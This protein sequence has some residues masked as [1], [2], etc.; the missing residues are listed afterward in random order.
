MKR[1]VLFLLLQTVIGGVQAQNFKFGKVSKEEVLEQVH[2]LDKE[3]NAA[4][5]FREYKVSYEYNSFSGFTL[6]TRVHERIKIYNKDGFDWANKVISVYKNNSKREEVTSIKG[7]TYNINDGKVE[8]EKLRNNG[9]LEEE[10][11]KY[12]NK[13]TLTMPAVKEG[14]VVEYE[15]SIRSPFLTSIDEI[16]LQY[17]IPTNRLEV[18]VSV[19]EFLGF[20]KHF[21]LKS[22]LDFPLTE[23]RKPVTHKINNVVNSR[24]N[25]VQLQ[26]VSDELSYILNIY[27]WTKNNIPALEEENHIDYLQNYAASL[28]WELQYTKFPNQVIENYAETW[29][30]VTS[31]IYWDEGYE[32]ELNRTGFFEEDLALVLK[33]LNSAEEK[34][35]AI[36]SFLKEKVKWNGYFGYLPEKG[37]RSAYKDGEG[38]VGDLNTL[39]TSML[40][41]AGLKAY[42]VLVSSKSNGIPVF[43]TRQGFN[44]V[45]SAVEIPGRFIFLDATDPNSAVNELPHRARNWQGRLIMDKENSTWVDIM[46]KEKSEHITTLNMKFGE[47]LNLE[48]KQRS[49]YSGLFAKRYRDT[50]MG[51]S[52]E[53]RLQ[54]LEKGKGNID[55]LNLKIEN[56]S[57][58]GS[59]VEQVFDFQL[60]SAVESIG[61]RIYLK[62][63]VYEA[64]D[65]SPFKADTRKYPIFFDFPSV[66]Q[67][68]VNLMV[69]TGYVV[70][71]LP[72]S[73]VLELN[74]GAGTFTFQVIQNKNFLRIHSVLEIN[75]IAFTPADYGALQDF[76]NKLV[77]KHTEAIV[78]K[79]S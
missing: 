27:E 66:H 71:T 37:T 30:G 33:D 47:D 77:D 72:E 25:S 74:S 5:L 2:P 73:V 48:G 75:N 15:Y 60:K 14:S 52:E 46:P 53:N 34:I 21:N 56:E 18:T 12:W 17:T 50:Y 78:F 32:T 70:E 43:P 29:E 57:L 11:N 22:G 58:I 51:T 68:T 40:K 9:I 38:N 69:P 54:S 1:I 23:S 45:I 13:T 8:E 16:L 28:K 7:F 79:K 59:D 35:T 20:R 6:V 3:A 19:P 24:G 55:I 76:Y 36:Y 41:Y 49:R 4:V 61:E 63:L 62:P 39:L 44:Y 31:T 42:P 65:E 10:V 64:V 26:G 67:T